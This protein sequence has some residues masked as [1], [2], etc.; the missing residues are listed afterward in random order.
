MK[1]EKIAIIGSGIAGLGSAYFL[2]KKYDITIFEKNDYAG[3]H[4]NITTVTEGK[5]SIP[6]DTAVMIFNEAK[7]PYFCRLLRILDV[8]TKWANSTLGIQH[9][10]TGLVYGV[11]T[12]KLLLSQPSNLINPSYWSLLNEIIRFGKVAPEVLK[13]EKFGNYTLVQYAK[14]RK[15]SDAFLY[16]FLVPFIAGLWSAD[17]KQMNGFPIVTLVHYFDNH[18]LLLP[19]VESLFGRNGKY[20]WRTFEG[21]TQVYRDRLLHLF[22]NALKLNMPVKK[23]KRFPTYVELTITNNKT[24]M[25]DR[26][27]FACHADEALKLLANPTNLEKE[28]LRTF[29][30]K[31]NT[32]TLHTDSSIMPQA[33]RSWAAFN[34]RLEVHNKKEQVT[35]NYYLNLLQQ[36]SAKKDY[37]L[38][39][40][41]DWS[42]DPKKI[43]QRFYYTHPVYSVPSAKAQSRLQELNK[44]GR[45]YFC[46]SYFRYAFH[47]DAFVS[48]LDACC[49]LTGEKLWEEELE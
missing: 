25:F 20:G 19:P 1:R 38:A 24:V 16:Q 47:E 8:P 26:V 17:R 36:F 14:E 42:I 48:A 41:N 43:M 3:G 29:L 21:G 5:R 2:Y 33:R 39:I 18:H 7:Y 31:K 34:C 32:V 40:G 11:P 27:I 4:S 37:F 46:G 10:P 15:F 49:A 13:N 23:V 22:P 35:F 28:L 30:Y 44:N 9:L 12:L 45:I 6:I